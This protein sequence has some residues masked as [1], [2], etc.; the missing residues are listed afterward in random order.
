MRLL[1]LPRHSGEAEGGVMG[2]R[3]QL[4]SALRDQWHLGPEPAGF[5]GPGD[6]AHLP[7]AVGGRA[8]AGRAWVTISQESQV[9]PRLLRMAKNSGATLGK[10]SSNSPVRLY[11]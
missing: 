11:Y 7:Q 9:K 1:T 4:L 10:Q 5:Q 8:C 6:L 3:L 2:W